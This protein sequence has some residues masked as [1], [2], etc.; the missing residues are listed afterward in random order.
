MAS[1]SFSHE[2]V[3]P[4][5]AS[6]VFSYHGRNQSILRLAPPWEK[7][8]LLNLTEDAESL[9]TLDLRIRLGSL[10]TNWQ[11]QR[12][13][14]AQK[15]TVVY[16]QSKGPF[17]YWKH[18]QSFRSLDDDS[19]SLRDLVQFSLPFAGLTNNR[20]GNH[21]VR[22]RLKRLFLYR[23]ST[24]Q[25]DMRHCTRLKAFPKS[26]VAITGGNGLIGS[27]LSVYLQAQGH[28]VTILSRS[29]KSRVWGIPVQQWDPRAKTADWKELDGNDA[30][31]HLA[32]ENLASGRWTT[33]KLQSM[34][35]SRV[36]STRF[37][38]EGF[39]KM[40]HPPKVFISPSGI[41]YY[42]DGADAELSETAEKGNGILANLCEEW[43]GAS[44][45][46]EAMG[47]RRVVL[48]IGIVLTP[49]GGALAKLLPIYK[50]GLGG[51]QGKGTQYWS[52]ISMDDL[53]RIFHTAL[54]DPDFEGVY[55]AVSPT[56]LQ[57]R[58]FSSALAEKVKRPGFCAA[59]SGVLSLLLGK[60][61]YETLLASQ[62]VHPQR[63]ET[64][65]FEFDFPTL[66]LALS[67]IFGR[68]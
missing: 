50:A 30:W 34:R 52:W 11:V 36:E 22:K 61:A 43:E 64:C 47:I 55:N 48:R 58:D 6:E 40:A 9:A 60:M 62:R 18:T 1:T 39:K 37:L 66:D 57:N 49:K 5:N 17:R 4:A 42:G 7:L 67:H 41:G 68:H 44:A 8:D 15:R 12:E 29:G 53:L 16:S 63:L 38:A 13:E 46:I 51:R 54:S 33:K 25:N 27:E 35:S 2:S 20:L 23:H 56:P 3:I 24:A 14:F 26:K 65:G 21:L 59:P 28:D 32:G 45:E 19:S 10:K 31:I